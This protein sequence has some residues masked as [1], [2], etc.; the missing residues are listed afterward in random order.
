MKEIGVCEYSWGTL[1]LDLDSCV[2]FLT[3][4]NKQPDGYNPLLI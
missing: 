2:H 1:I 3:G 4:V